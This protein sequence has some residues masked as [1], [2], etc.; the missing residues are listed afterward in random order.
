MKLSNGTEAYVRAG[1]T[2]KTRQTAAAESYKLL[3]KPH[4]VQMLSSLHAEAD[5]KVVDD[6]AEQLRLW[7]AVVNH[8]PC[9][10]SEIVYDACRYCHGDHHE[11]HWRVPAEFEKELA[12]YNRLPDKIKEVE[13]APNDMGGYGYSRKLLPHPDCPMCDGEGEMRVVFHPSA[14]LDKDAALAFGGVQITQNSIKVMTIDRMAA[15]KKIA[16]HLGMFRQEA[17][18]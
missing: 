8:D 10:L 13:T 14:M 2:A 7:R 11:Y 15:S 4:I 3:R 17:K 1:Y 18:D 6:Y 12:A 5:A 16:K 9:E